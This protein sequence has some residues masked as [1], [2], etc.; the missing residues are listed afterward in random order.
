MK[1]KVKAVCPKCHKKGF[2]GEVCSK[3]KKGLV[4]VGKG[5]GAV[6]EAAVTVALESTGAGGVD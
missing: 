2:L 6:A 1:N 4:A 5:A 3:C